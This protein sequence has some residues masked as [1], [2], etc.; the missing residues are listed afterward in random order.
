MC[1]RCVFHIL[2][3]LLVVDDSPDVREFVT[4]ALSLY[5]YR[6]LQ[7]RHG[8]EAIR[9]LKEETTGEI[10]LVLTDIAMPTMDG[11]ELS[12]RIREI[13]PASKILF[14]SGNVDYEEV[15]SS[16]PAQQAPLLEKPFTSQLLVQRVIG[17]LGV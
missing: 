17:L 6:V 1:S 4:D 3:T 5:G 8:E 7:A 14:M 9:I 16:L 11:I 2:I 13:D 12:E 15:I 10:A